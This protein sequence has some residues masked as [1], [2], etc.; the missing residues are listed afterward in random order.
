[1]AHE[2]DTREEAIGHLMKAIHD[3]WNDGWTIRGIDPAKVYI[4]REEHGNM[5]PVEPDPEVAAEARAVATSGFTGD[6]SQC[7]GAPLQPSGTCQVCTACGNT[8]G[9]S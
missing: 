2:F 5:E 4:F 3:L 6:L 7:C 1:M 9:C 8:T